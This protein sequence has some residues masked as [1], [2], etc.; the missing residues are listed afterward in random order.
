MLTGTTIK[1]SIRYFALLQD[2]RGLTQEEYATG[3]ATLLDLYNELRHLHSFSLPA[4]K[5]RVAVNTEFAEWQQALQENDA[6]VFI[7]PVAGG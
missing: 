3:A 4:S 7:P 1:V 2:E 5:L 6:V